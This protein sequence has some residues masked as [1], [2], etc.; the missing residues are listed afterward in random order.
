VRGSIRVDVGELVQPRAG[1][2]I[3]EEAFV[4]LVGKH[5]GHRPPRGSRPGAALAHRNDLAKL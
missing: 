4:A 1:P 2:G 5:L 3:I